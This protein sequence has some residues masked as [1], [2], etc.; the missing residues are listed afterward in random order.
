MKQK[1][2]D[3]IKFLIYVVMGVA[4]FIVS[5]LWLTGQI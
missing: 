4:S 5:L 3:F 1:D 2:R